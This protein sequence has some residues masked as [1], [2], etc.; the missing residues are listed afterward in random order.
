MPI[1]PPTA[2][3]GSAPREV[4]GAP[5]GTAQPR[6]RGA[7]VDLDGTMVDTL[8]D[9]EAAL[10]LTLRDLGH[11]PVARGFIERTIG[12]GSEHLI[13]RTLEQ[14]GA[15]ASAYERAWQ[16]YQ[17]HYER[18]NG[19]HSDLFAGVAEGL[20]RLQAAG[21]R[22]VCITNKPTRFARELLA[23]K[24]L[25]GRFEQVFGGDAFERRK[26]DPLPLLKACEA[27][28]LPPREVLMVG[29]SANDAIAARA[30]G[31]AVVLVRY[32]YNHGEPIDAVE[33]DAHVDRIDQIDLARLAASA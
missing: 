6:W 8:G 30:A 19:A 3:P 12:K 4:G 11:E 21:L 23:L 10:A 31:C 1:E 20:A 17:G 28:G 16:L 26:P 18:I 32:G 14:A 15:P 27:L 33:A 29:D 25:A 9:F 7:L 2:V 13:R 24:S 5:A 22:L